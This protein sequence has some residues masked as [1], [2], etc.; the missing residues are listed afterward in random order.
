MLDAQYDLAAIGLPYIDIIVRVEDSFLE[1]F[2]LVKRTVRDLQPA[3]ILAIRSELTDYTVYPGGSPSNTCA[4]IH[5]LGGKAVFMGRV[6]D[7]A[8]GRAFR[9]AF[10]AGNVLFPNRPYGKD[11]RA[12]SGIVIVMMTPDDA[13]TV[14]ANPGVGD[15]L[16]EADIFPDLIA[17][18]RILF[19]QAHFFT[20]DT[21]KAAV[22]KAI[23]AAKAA[24]RIVALSLHGH[25]FNPERK[26]IFLEQHMKKADMLVG[27]RD[28]FEILFGQL[29][30][31]ALADQNRLIVMTDGGNGAYILGRGERIHVPPHAV[32]APDNTVGAGDAFAAGFF[33][34]Y[35]NGLALRKCG[36][37]GAEAANA[38]LDIP[39][40]R[41]VGS[42]KNIADKYLQS[43]PASL[44][45]P[46]LAEGAQ[47]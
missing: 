29:D 21:S 2:G 23:E 39:G 18:S 41:P 3:Q 47:T 31:K 12:T 45:R 46:I 24:K 16:T 14:V 44:R 8:T 33:Y 6:C 34:G 27:N 43:A 40:A 37:L 38:V 22:G 13:A 42:W 5:A 9:N 32:S 7:D 1:R 11:P 10:P 35:V 26:T 30:M 19:L 25:R 36:E 15:Y 4:G 20:V 17:D 28:E